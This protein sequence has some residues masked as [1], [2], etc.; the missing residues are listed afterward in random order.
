MRCIVKRAV[1]L[2]GTSYGVGL[3]D[4]PVGHCQGWFFDA[5]VADGNIVLMDAPVVAAVVIDQVV[6]TA[7]ESDS[8]DDTEI[9]EPKSKRGKK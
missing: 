3:R 1:S 6:E 7:A 2:F 8:I 9:I 4:I 5:C